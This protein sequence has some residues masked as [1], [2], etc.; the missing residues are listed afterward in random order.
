M[1]RPR[2]GRAGTTGGCGSDDLE[3]AWSHRAATAA[4]LKRI[5]RACFE[6]IVVR[7]DGEV[8]DMVLHGHGGSLGTRSMTAIEEK[9][10]I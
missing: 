6:E 9:I 2:G 7:K 3:C 8:F 5:L 4:T 1:V 10:D